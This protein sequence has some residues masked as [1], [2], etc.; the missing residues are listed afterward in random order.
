MLF[1]KELDQFTVGE[2][3]D[4]AELEIADAACSTRTTSP[5]F[6]VNSSWIVSHADGALETVTSELL[7]ENVLDPEYQ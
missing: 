6:R 1:I 2:E 3:A 4:L 7:A 5:R